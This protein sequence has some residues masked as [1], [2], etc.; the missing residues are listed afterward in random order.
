MGTK[1]WNSKCQNIVAQGNIYKFSQ[2]AELKKLLLATKN[3][4]LVEASPYD[5]IWGIGLKSD[6]PAAQNPKQWKGTNWLGQAITK[7]RTHLQECENIKSK[8]RSKGSTLD[9]FVKPVVKKKKV[10]KKG[11]KLI[12]KKGDLL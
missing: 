3:K 4:I 9:D 11:N 5:T 10:Q 12:I 6:D 7:A 1:I 8:K 2:N